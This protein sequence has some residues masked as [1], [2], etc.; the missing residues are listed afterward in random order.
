MRWLQLLVNG[1]NEPVGVCGENIAFTWQF[2]EENASF[3]QK[4]Y[5]IL[6]ATKESLIYDET[7]DLWDSGWIEGNNNCN[8]PCNAS[9]LPQ[10]SPIYW[11]V[12][13]QGEDG[14]IHKA[15]HSHFVVCPQKWNAQWIWK[16]HNIETNSYATF[17][18]E[19]CVDTDI[20]A[21][22]LCVSAHS[23]YKLYINGYRV[24]GEVSP[25]PSNPETNKLFLGYDVTALLHKGQNKIE[26]TVLYQGG[27]GENY[28]NGKPGFFCELHIQTP[29]VQLNVVT[30]CNW[31]CT[32]ETAYEPNMPFQENRRTT[33]VEHYNASQTGKGLKWANAVC[34][35]GCGGMILQ[36]IPEG[37]V[38]YRIIPQ[39]IHREK[40]IE[41]YD[42]GSIVSGWVR[43]AIREK[44][45]T[46]ISIRYSEKLDDNGRVGHN[47]A[48][49]DSENYCDYYTVGSEDLE[50]W[51]PCFS[52]KAFRYV[53]V[54]GCNILNQMGIQ[55]E[56]AHTAIKQMGRFHS[57]KALLNRIFDAC[58]Q[59]QTNNLLG[60]IVDCPH[61]EQA[62]YLADADMQA[63]NL[64]YFFDA[65]KII[66]KTLMDFENAQQEDGTFPFV[67]PSNYQHEDFS[68]KIP[69][70]D[71][72]FC[73]L[74][75]KLYFATGNCAYV[76]KYYA[77][78]HK[79]MCHYLNQREENGLVPKS[80][81]W[82]ISD[83]PAPK[84]DH[85][86]RY[87]TAE[88]IKVY[89]NT[90]LMA[91]MAG[92]I[93]NHDDAI[94]YSEQAKNMKRSIRHGLLDRKKLL[95]R[96]SSDSNSYAAGVNALALCY[97]LFCDMEIDGAVSYLVNTQWESSTL[98]TLNVL[99]ALF[100][101]GE[102][103]T[104]YKML[105]KET[106]PSWGAMIRK[107]DRTIWEGFKN[108]N[109]HCHAW[110]AYPSRMFV[111]YL[112]G[113]KCEEPGFSRVSIKPF[114]PQDIN[115]LNGTVWTPQGK[116]SA[117]IERRY[118]TLRM[119]LSVPH[120]VKVDVFRPVEGS[121]F[122][123]QNTVDAGKYVLYL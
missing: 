104:A 17:R 56:V 82:H 46:K 105:S 30:D 58:M 99:K 60:Q 91:Q 38:E 37:E 14:L 76:K 57:D 34:V 90:R 116:L 107:G 102:A 16:D 69:E 119:E 23:N 3:V 70:W 110:N 88:N 36:E 123:F 109:S 64:L 21:A 111:E 31:L 89:Q 27:S 71:L 41:V 97:D 96:D 120:G 84:V 92:I 43:L 87:L 103:E 54:T 79:M 50:I 40:G 6:V 10:M 78:C 118:R 62:Q 112:V 117:K 1:M 115:E 80:Q 2:D 55:V 18:R 53:E 122:V 114:M 48:D 20:D 101:H 26:A 85:S 94:W 49:E 65:E 28:V 52:Y 81:F 39:C 108:I 86:G 63:E 113:I 32:G 13:L 98:L 12:E 42:A 19:F 93:G 77:V 4:A 24:G 8:I 68:L 35:G 11:T 5:R 22:F 61:R 83:W 15:Q 45:G 29:N 100:E 9:Q 59:T 47:V 75:W 72:H 95:F 106:I 74:L 73:S 51:C 25:A 121:G 67:Y 66:N 44:P 33:A 7:P